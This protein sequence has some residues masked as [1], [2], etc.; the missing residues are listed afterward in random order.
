MR[1]LPRSLALV[2]LA[3]MGCG[4]D[5]STA[6]LVHDT[7]ASM[8]ADAAVFADVIAL[9]N[10]FS[11]EG[12]AFGAGTTFYVASLATGAIFRGDARTG[13]GDLLVPSQRG[14]SA[15]GLKYDARGNRLFVAGSRT[16]QAYVYDA[17][18]GATLAV[19]QLGDPAAGVTSINDMVVTR[20]AVYFTDDSRP[21]IYRLPL[22]PGG[23][24]PRANAVQ[25]IPL[26]GDFPF[27]PN[28]VNGNGI[29]ATPNEDALIIDN[30][31]GGGLY[32]VD[33]TTGVATRIDLD[34]DAMTWAD[35]LVLIGRT[36]Y[37]VRGPF[38][39]I[40]EVRLS[41]DFTTGVIEGAITGQALDFPSS[42]AVFGSS[43]YAVNARFE[44]APG[45]DVEY[46][47]VR[48]VR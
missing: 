35:G 11:A 31:F 9:P 10:G 12:I 13:T 4:R 14:R 27:V 46:Q 34:G 38:N 18:T 8:L 19:Y 32:R 40:A 44:V 21:V 41:P 28:G 22:G 43:L 47:V 15:C 20:K 36:L 23:A 17:S 42:I 30:T 39:Q 26:T 5:P 1:N 24:L 7:N 16:G 2:S 33:P 37:A 45:P 25:T 3:L 6:P 48:L 29:V